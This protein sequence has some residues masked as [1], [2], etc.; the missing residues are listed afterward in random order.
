MYARATLALI[1]IDKIE[2]FRKIYEE[3]VVPAAKKQKGFRGISL[4]VNLKTGEGM[5]ISYWDNEE[6]ALA[7]EKSRY[8]Q[9]Q[10]AKFIPFYKRQPIREGYEILVKV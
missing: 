5:S 8:Y 4:M 9:E 6:D 10:V 2:Q 7:N 1:N 3:S